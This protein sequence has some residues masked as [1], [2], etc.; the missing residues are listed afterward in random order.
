MHVSGIERIFALRTG[1]IIGVDT[2]VSV[3][4]AD[5]LRTNDFGRVM[6]ISSSS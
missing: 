6:T 1:V 5:T 4:T 2:Y 3:E